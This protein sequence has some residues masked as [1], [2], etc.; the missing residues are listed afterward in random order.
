MNLFY[1]YNRGALYTALIVLYS[2]TAGIA[3]YVAASYYKQASTAR[4]LKIESSVVASVKAACETAATYAEL[5]KQC[6]TRCQLPLFMQRAQLACTDRYKM[7][8]LGIRSL[9]T[10][11][12]L[13]SNPNLTQPRTSFSRQA[14]VSAQQSAVLFQAALLPRCCSSAWTLCC[15]STQPHACC[16]QME[17]TN[18]VRNVLTTC[19]VYCGPFFLMFCFNNTVAWTHRVRKPAWSPPSWQPLASL[20]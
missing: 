15:H 3:G 14:N 2:L 8:V 20:Q 10:S 11:E 4:D 7:V 5:R 19:F 16:P 6:C 9:P 17:G 13:K 1:P 12:T 18:W